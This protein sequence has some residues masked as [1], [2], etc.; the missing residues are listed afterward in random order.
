MSFCYGKIETRRVN[1]PDAIF[2]VN[3]MEGKITGCWLVNEESIFFLILL[4]EESKITRS[5]LVV[6]LPSNSLF[7]REVVFLLASRFEIVDEEYIEELKDKSENENTKNSTESWKNV[8]KKWENEK[9]LQA[10]L[11]EYRKT[12]S[13]SNDCCSFKHSKIQ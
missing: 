10:N 4:C 3:N 6:R 5:R 11:E 2:R 8:F 1:F 9:R 7:S 12:M 13:T